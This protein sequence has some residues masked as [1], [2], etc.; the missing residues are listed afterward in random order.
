MRTDFTPISNALSAL[1]DTIAGMH[2]EL[3]DRANAER[4]EALDL[5]ARMQ[6]TY[7]DLSQF[8]DIVGSAADAL[9]G[10]SDVAD[11][12]GSKVYDAIDGGFPAIPEC[13]YQDFV[14]FCTACGNTIS[15]NDEFTII[16]GE[17]YETVCAPA[18]NTEETDD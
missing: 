13:D 2:R 18:I 8:G 6:D 5:Y 16:D 10:V 1:V 9:C 3:L 12:I 14:D 11:D 7:A 4:R 17:V 15:T